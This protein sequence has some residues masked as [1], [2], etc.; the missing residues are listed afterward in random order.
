MHIRP[1]T[2]HLKG[3]VKRLRRIDD[4]ELC[5]RFGKNGI[6]DHVHLF[7]DELRA[8]ENLGPYSQGLQPQSID[9]SQRVSDDDHP[10]LRE[11]REA[12]YS[13]VIVKLTLALS[14]RGV[15]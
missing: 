4:E 6:A 7:N 13:R 5:H 8:S 2:R 3:K 10:I 14:S 12:G 15:P 11:I 1:R 9:T